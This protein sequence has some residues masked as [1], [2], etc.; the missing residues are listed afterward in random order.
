MKSMRKREGEHF[1]WVSNHITLFWIGKYGAVCYKI[2]EMKMSQ[3]A[4]DLHFTSKNVE[5]LLILT[6]ILPKKVKYL[7]TIFLLNIYYHLIYSSTNKIEPK[8]ELYHVGLTGKMEIA[9]IRPKFLWEIERIFTGN[10]SNVYFFYYRRFWDLSI[11][12]VLI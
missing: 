3:A 1:S 6:M 4:P 5:H 2:K 7:H 8:E 12:E 9:R 11:W 10:F